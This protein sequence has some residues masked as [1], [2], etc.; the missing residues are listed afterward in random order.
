MRTTFSYRRWTPSEEEFLRK[1]YQTHTYPQLAE[2]LGRTYE[3][4]RHRCERLGLF[5]YKRR[6][7][8]QKRGKLESEVKVTIK[9]WLEVNGYK[10]KTEYKPLHGYVPRVDFYIQP[11]IIIEC[12]GGMNATL[13]LQYLIG[14]LLVQ[15]F[16][17]INHKIYCA[18]PKELKR[19]IKRLE[20]LFNYYNMPF[21]IL[22][23]SKDIVEVH[24]DKY[25]VFEG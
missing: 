7:S 16:C 24:R 11:N 14:Q 21:G 4:V 23:V 19:M 12:K 9:K 10:F 13:Y 25:K 3:S 17:Y 2:K 5:A 6:V 1:N 20:M 22:L 15:N 18:I 8:P